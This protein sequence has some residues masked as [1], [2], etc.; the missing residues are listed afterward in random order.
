MTEASGAPRDRTGTTQGTTGGTT[1]PP[2]I[3]AERLP[4]ETPTDRVRATVAVASVV[5]VTAG[6]ALWLAIGWRRRR[7]A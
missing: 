2:V 4:A 7:R 1:P 3:E 5:M 6:I